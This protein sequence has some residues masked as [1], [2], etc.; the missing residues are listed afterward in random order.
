MSRLFGAG[1]TKTNAP[2][3][4]MIAGFAV[5][6]HGT[7]HDRPRSPN[8]CMTKPGKTENAATPSP[9]SPAEFGVTRPTIYR[10]LD[11]LASKPRAS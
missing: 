10:H 8:R 1:V 2:E 11:A 9:K 3:T 6:V 5:Q 7:P 4:L